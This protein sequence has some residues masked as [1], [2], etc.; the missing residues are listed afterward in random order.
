[1]AGLWQT[2]VHVSR[3]GTP[4]DGRNVTREFKALLAAAKLPNV[5]FHDLRHIAATL[6]L[7]EGLSAG[8]GSA[9]GGTKNHSTIEKE[10]LG[11]ALRRPASTAAGRDTTC[12]DA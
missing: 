5:R 6:L 2:D 10:R 3:F 7:A 12:A 1:V 11:E 8:R 9:E 4:L